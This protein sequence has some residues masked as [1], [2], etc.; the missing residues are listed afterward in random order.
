M[1][2]IKHTT[3]F[4]KKVDENMTKKELLEVIKALE[5]EVK[6]QRFLVIEQERQ[7]ILEK[8]TE[9]RRYKF[10]TNEFTLMVPLYHIKKV[11][12]EPITK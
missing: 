8:I 9:D 1:K 6:D 10:K 3:Y 11:L 12:Y 7:R 2:R 4:G 5:K